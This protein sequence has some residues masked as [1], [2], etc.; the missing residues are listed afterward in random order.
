MGISFYNELKKLNR[1]KNLM[2]LLPQKLRF[3]AAKYLYNYESQELNGINMFV[4][5][6]N[7]GLVCLINTKDVIGWKI[8]FFGEYES[9]TNRTLEK[10]IKQGDVVIE[11]GANFGS[12]TLLLSRLAGKNGHIYAFEPNPYIFEQLKINISSNELVNVSSYDYALGE[13]NNMIHFNIYPKG[14]CNPGMSSK[15]MET[16]ITRKIDVNQKTI[17]TFVKEQDIT[18]L[19][20]LKMDIQG[21]EMDVIEGGTETINKFKPI[22]F[23]EVDEIYNDKKYMFQ[24]FKSFGY[25]VYFIEE[26]TTVEMLTLADIRDGNWLM[27]CEK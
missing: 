25:T 9:G 24:K 17:D 12:E 26:R 18:K 20:F 6:Q 8:F 19:N 2:A 5:L 11:A 4:P 10:Y 1:A 16:P 23:T 13:S 14:F 15:Y 21:A 3:R 7:E 22:I 27:I